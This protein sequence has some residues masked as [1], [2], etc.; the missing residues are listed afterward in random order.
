MKFI[1][2]ILIS[3]EAEGQPRQRRSPQLPWIELMHETQWHLF[4]QEPGPGWKGSPCHHFQFGKLDIFLIGEIF[5]LP[6][7]PGILDEYLINF[8]TGSKQ[9][10]DLNG[11]CILLAWDGE[12]RQWHVWTNRFGTSHLY[13]ADSGRKRSLGSFFPALAEQASNKQLDWENLAG[14]FNF[15]FFPDDST[16]YTD[17]KV[18]KP[19][20]ETVFDEWGRL[21]RQQRYWSWN[22]LPD[23]TRSYED[24]LSEFSDTFKTIIKEQVQSGRVSLPISGGL[25]SRTIAA[26]VPNTQDH[27]AN[28]DPLWAFS[29]GYTGSSVECEI[30]RQVAEECGFY[31]DTYTVQPYLFDQMNLV[32]ASLEGF[33]D[34]TMC[35]QASRIDEISIHSDYLLGGHLG[36]LVLDDAGLSEKEPGNLFMDDLNQYA[37]HKIQKKGRDWFNKN[38]LQPLFKDQP[39]ENL[40]KQKIQETLEPLKKI[41]DYDFLIK[42]FKIE[43]YCFRFTAT[44]FRMYQPAAFPRLP[45][46]D[47]R[48]IDF[49]STIPSKYL[50]GRRLQIDYLKRFAPDLAKIPWQTFDANLYHFQHFNTWLLPKRA[51]KKAWRLLT[52]QKVIQRNWEVQFLNPQGRAGLQRWLLQDG[53]K[54]H[55]LLKVGD[56]RALLEDLYREPTAGRGYAVSMLLTFS[57]WLEHY[58]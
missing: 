22:Y 15:G 1:G 23:Q 28:Q 3:F 43:Q 13:Y 54:L 56:V 46:Y 24:T 17:V 29:Y 21:V 49:V 32:M 5:G 44:G 35:R 52:N 36:D 6:Q 25:D 9:A 2:D 57:A 41:N 16:Y 10:V 48:L 7:R 55:D 30:A 53:L 4:I 37:L 11:H 51:L 38:L 31:F 33:N 14:F 47:T 34:I 20:T 50:A 45:F 12:S 42:A 58:G 39:I 26:V 18:L 27:V 40:L 8:V 19:A